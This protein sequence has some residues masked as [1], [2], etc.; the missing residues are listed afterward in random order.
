MLEYKSVSYTHLDVYKRQVSG[1]ISMEAIIKMMGNIMDEYGIRQNV[2]ARLDKQIEAVSYT[3][4]DVYKRQRLYIPT[5]AQSMLFSCILC[6]V[7]RN[8]F[9]VIFFFCRLHLV[10]T[11]SRS[12]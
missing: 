2:C 8:L 12:I 6:I 9:Y 7:C 3:H 11:L 4:L 5:N 1:S 10:R